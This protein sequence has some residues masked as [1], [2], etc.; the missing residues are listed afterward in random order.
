MV[1]HELPAVTVEEFC[2]GGGDLEGRSWP[3][4]E[5]VKGGERP[6]EP[7]QTLAARLLA[8]MLRGTWG[9]RS[10]DYSV[11]RA[12]FGDRLSPAA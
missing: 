5:L 4:R 3:A 2:E 6:S 7:S 10:S 11:Q 9:R 1:H 12:G 8:A